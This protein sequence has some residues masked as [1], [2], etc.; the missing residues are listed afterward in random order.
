MVRETVRY[1]ALAAVVWAS[2]LLGG[3]CRGPAE[4]AAPPWR[5]PTGVESDRLSGG[6]RYWLN[7]EE[8]DRRAAIAALVAPTGRIP[9]TAGKLR[10]TLTGGSP[11]E[12]KAVLD[13]LTGHPALTGWR[14]KLLVQAYPETTPILKRTGH[15]VGPALA[16]Y[17]QAP[18]GRCVGRTREAGYK[19]PEA[20]A[21]GLVECER[22]ASADEKRPPQASYD[23]ARDPDLWAPPP[24]PPPPDGVKPAPPGPA[25]GPSPPAGPE[26]WLQVPWQ[27]WSL[28]GAVFVLL[29]AMALRRTER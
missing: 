9:D 26:W 3:A 4:G 19:G 8:V 12:R 29:L 14:A 11:A 27:A 13:D 20:L 16:I 6:P 15:V 25:P 2:V 5:P 10:L 28:A 22:R 17:V 18:G 7:G 21:A 23:P 1:G 24:A